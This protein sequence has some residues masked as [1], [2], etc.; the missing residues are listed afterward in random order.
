MRCNTKP[1][2]KES[3]RSQLQIR[4]GSHLCLCFYFTE[5]FFIPV[6]QISRLF[7]DYFS[8]FGKFQDFSRSGSETCEIPN[9]SRISKLRMNPGESRFYKSL[10]LLTHAAIDKL[11]KWGTKWLP[12][13]LFGCYTQHQTP[14]PG[15][16]PHVTSHM[17]LFYSVNDWSDAW[18]HFWHYLHV[19][20]A[21]RH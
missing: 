2:V 1:L 14:T 21:R 4:V 3:W 20:Q 9:Y 17:S 6:W 5:M 8:W 15:V 11:L 19:L 7:K 12:F 16:I 13:I 10:L 18:E